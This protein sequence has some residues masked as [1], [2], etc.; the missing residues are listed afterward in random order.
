[1]LHPPPLPPNPGSAPGGEREGER[2]RGVGG[3]KRGERIERERFVVII[4]N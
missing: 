4:F 1:M 3:R 2:K